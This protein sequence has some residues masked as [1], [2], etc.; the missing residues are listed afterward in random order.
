MSA[1]RVGAIARDDD[2][3]FGFIFG[4]GGSASGPSGVITVFA[5]ASTVVKVVADVF[6][7]EVA[8]AFEA[9]GSAL[10][11]FG[12]LLLLVELLV[13]VL[14]IEVSCVKWRWERIMT[15]T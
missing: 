14:E 6:V 11:V 15:V 3:R 9:A 7:V 13:V 8:V 10:L 5:V 12:V 1:Q 2:G 4:S